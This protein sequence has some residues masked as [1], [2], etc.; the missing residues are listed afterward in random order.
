MITLVKI[1]RTLEKIEKSLRD[2]VKQG[3]DESLIDIFNTVNKTFALTESVIYT[4]YDS[5]FFNV[6][7]DKKLES[8]E[9][10]DL[11]EKAE[12]AIKDI[13]PIVKISYIPVEIS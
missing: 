7:Y 11:F 3:E 10:F 12:I 4:E 5:G 13:Y 1:E 9:L 8:D 6:Y 2:I